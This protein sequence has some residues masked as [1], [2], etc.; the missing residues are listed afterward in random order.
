[1]PDPVDY[2]TPPR[3]IQPA[4]A[5]PPPM[6][7]K[8]FHAGWLAMLAAVMIALTLCWLM[9]RPLADVFL[10]ATVLVIVFYPF[11]QALLRRS[12]R[13]MTS[14]LLSCGFVVGVIVLPLTLL[15][16]VL[17]KE[18]G[19]ATEYL[20]NNWSRLTD[21]ESAH[22]QRVKAIVGEDR[23]KTISSKEGLRD[24][25][26]QALQA[27]GIP[28]AAGAGVVVGNVLMT[29]LKIVFVVFTMF[30]LFRDGERVVETLRNTLPLD[31]VQ[32]AHI[33]ARTRDV[34]NASVHGNMVIALIQGIMGGLGFW[35]LG[36]PSPVLWGSIMIL[37]S[38]I[39]VIGS[40]IVWVPTV[41]WLLLNGHPFKA[42]FL[43]VWGGGAISSVDYFLRPRLVGGRTRL[44]EL[45]VFFSV[46]GGLQFFGI[47]GIVLGPVLVAITL[48]L[49]DVFRKADRPMGSVPSRT[50]AEAQATFRDVPLE[51]E[52]KEAGAEVPKSVA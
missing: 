46:V 25:I 11:H 32:A 9:I 35:W 2:A 13:P 23:V 52:P 21:P 40:T 8:R 1:M 5:P 39:P 10:W 47:L 16:V 22:M 17:V 7:L 28:L 43:V 31:S 38:M 6:T 26:Q 45:L 33:F 18:A 42:I 24:A 4:A 3:L 14:A 27:I 30:Y 50:L 12:Q 15:T 48:A 41:G 44:H 34:I 36:L 37:L 20:S 19:D 49:L 51:R 29:A